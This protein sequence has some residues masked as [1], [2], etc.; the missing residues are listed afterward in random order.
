ML[1]FQSSLKDT[2]DEMGMLVAVCTEALLEGRG[3]GNHVSVA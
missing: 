2:L 3:T 1:L